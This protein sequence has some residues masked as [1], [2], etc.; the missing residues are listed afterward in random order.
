MVFGGLMEFLYH[1]KAKVISVYDGDTI[2]ADI[3]LGCGIWLHNESL[4]LYG[5]DTPEM[6]GEEREQGLIAR[7]FLRD[8][9]LGKEIFIKTRK[10]KTGK[11]GRLLATIFQVEEGTPFYVN[12]NELLVKEGY[13]VERYY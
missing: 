13:A 9:I 11:Y 8:K 3:S 1:Y 7:D 4:R 12:I 6:R 5:I 2:R 10:D